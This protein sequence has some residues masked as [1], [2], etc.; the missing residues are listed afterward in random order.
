MGKNKII[1]LVILLTFLSAQF[2]SQIE[3][4]NSGGQE[5]LGIIL[6]KCAEYCE[7]L[8]GSVLYFVCTEKIIEDIFR[9]VPFL[10]D[11]GRN[12]YCRR[13]ANC[14]LLGRACS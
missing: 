6:K 2:F 13:K 1:L 3:N 14:G 5:E 11:E 10:I 7:M 12:I 9:G 8:S 4:S